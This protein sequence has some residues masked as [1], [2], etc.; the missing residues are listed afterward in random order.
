MSKISVSTSGESSTTTRTSVWGLKYVPGRIDEVLELEAARVGHSA[1]VLSPEVAQLA[2]DLGLD[3]Q[4]LL[5]HAHAALVAGDHELADLGH[6]R[7]VGV[8]RRGAQQR[9]SSASMSSGG[10]PARAR[11]ARCAPRASGGSR[12]RATRP[13]PT[14][15]RRRRRLPSPATARR[16]RSARRSRRAHGERD[17]GD[18]R[19]ADD[20]DDEH[21]PE[22]VL[23]R[24]YSVAH[25]E[26]REAKDARAAAPGGLPRAVA[27]W[28]S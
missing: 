21:D 23:H 12:R 16:A 3:V 1:G 8:G 25:V 2:G 6:Q 15:A 28:C 27:G 26:A 4:R 13:R 24:T 11:G 22:R 5:A 20:D 19:G 14:A 7:R 17:H 10:L 9:A 18:D